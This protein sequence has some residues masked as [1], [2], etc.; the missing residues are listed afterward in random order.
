[1]LLFLLK[2]VNSRFY[3]VLPLLQMELQ[4]YRK[5]LKRVL[6]QQNT[7][8]CQEAHEDLRHRSSFFPSFESTHRCSVWVQSET[9][10]GRIEQNRVVS[11]YNPT[12]TPR[13]LYFAC[14]KIADIPKLWS[15]VEQRAN[16]RAKGI[17]YFH[18]GPNR[19]YQQLMIKN[20]GKF[21]E[22]LKQ[23]TGA[24]VTLDSVTGDHLRIDG[25]TASV[26][27]GTWDND[28]ILTSSDLA[29]LA[30]ELICLQIELYR[31]HCIRQQ[32]W[33]LDE[34]GL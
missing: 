32:S 30:E 2:M 9:D 10:M 7:T 13:K 22:Y 23:V 15:M 16:D 11:E 21:F 31:D 3:F 14:A 17:C 5:E 25:G 1:M 8:R 29:C 24:V 20:S 4:F 26:D 12:A 28:C 18:L 6:E 19:M 33:I 27:L 34:I